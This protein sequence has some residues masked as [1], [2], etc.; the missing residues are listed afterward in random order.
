MFLFVFIYCHI[1]DHKDSFWLVNTIFLISYDLLVYNFSLNL[2]W[3]ELWKTI[4]KLAKIVCSE[5][6]EIWSSEKL[7][8][9]HSRRERQEFKLFPILRPKM[10]FAL[11]SGQAYSNLHCQ[12]SSKS[13]FAYLWLVIRFGI[14]TFIS[15]G[16]DFFIC[17][18]IN[19]P[20]MNQNF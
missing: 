5:Y 20:M 8:F 10:I 16:P 2:L 18:A 17:S 7:F 13:Q 1:L 3:S 9:C 4:F 12:Y 19:F 15:E 6:H 11:L 14:I